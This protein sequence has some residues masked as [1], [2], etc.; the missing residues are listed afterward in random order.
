MAQ[1]GIRTN[2]PPVGLTWFHHCGFRHNSLT[3]KQIKWFHELILWVLVVYQITYPVTDR[4][5]QVS[6]LKKRPALPCCSLLCCGVFL[7]NIPNTQIILMSR[8]LFLWRPYSAMKHVEEQFA[9][10][11]ES[12]FSFPLHAVPW[13]AKCFMLV[14]CHCY[15]TN[16]FRLTP[17]GLHHVQLCFTDALRK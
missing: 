5:L 15:C 13:P 7:L 9:S 3:S 17:T 10:L 6:Y 12:N 14:S 1:P 4:Q 2:R 11:S 8:C 16:A